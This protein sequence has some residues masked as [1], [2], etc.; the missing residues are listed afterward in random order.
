MVSS[1]HELG[2][3][4]GS[5][6]FPRISSIAVATI[7]FGDADDRSLRYYDTFTKTDGAWRFTERKLYVDW[8]EERSLS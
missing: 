3:E 7:N 4:R 6:G 1:L 5:T 8:L 2:S